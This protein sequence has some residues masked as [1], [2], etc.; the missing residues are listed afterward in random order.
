MNKNISAATMNKSEKTP[1]EE[2][3][4][5]Q[6]EYDP[7]VI[8]VLNH[9]WLLLGGAR[10]AHVRW[11]RFRAYLHRETCSVHTNFNFDFKKLFPH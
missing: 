10:R 5:N 7:Y 2:M 4:L 8:V 11:H 9:L 6:E 1:K 3:V